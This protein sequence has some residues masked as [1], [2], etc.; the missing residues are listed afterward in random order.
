M[1][2]ELFSTVKVIPY[3]A[4]DVVDKHGFLSAVLGI[5]VGAAGELTLAIEESD[6]EAGTFTA[7]TDT[8]ALLGSDSATV[9][10]GDFVSVNIDVEGMKRYIT[11]TPS[12]EGTCAVALGDPSIAPI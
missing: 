7:I 1:K 9:A 4:G 6:E 5:T 8:F 10:S 12:L 11:I 2:R 3:T